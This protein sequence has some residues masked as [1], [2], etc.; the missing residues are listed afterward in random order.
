MLVE[1]VVDNPGM[2]MLPGMFG[3]AT[4]Q[5]NE[6]IESNVLPART[7]RFDE[8]G[9]AYVYVLDSEDRVQI[10]DIETGNDDGKQIEVKGDLQSGQRVIDIGV[11]P[12]AVGQ[13]VAVI[14][15]Q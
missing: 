7:I 4:I 5:T 3:Q 9:K 10:V 6:K 15:S 11:R 14:D 12:L 8:S 13:K 2:R 1:C